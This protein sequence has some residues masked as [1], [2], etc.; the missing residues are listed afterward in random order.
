MTQGS[1]VELQCSQSSSDQNM[2]W[3]HQRSSAGIQLIM[4]SVYMSVPERGKN[5]S[6]RFTSTRPKT[7]NITL[8]ISQA[9]E[10]DTDVQCQSQQKVSQWPSQTL[11]TQGSSVELQCIQSSSDT[12]MYWYCQQSS[13]EIHLIMLSVYKNEPERGKN[14]SGRFTSTR[15][16]TENITLSISQA[17]ESDTDV[18]CQSQ[19]KV[20]QWP[21]QTLMTQGSSVELQCSQSSSD[22]YMYWYCQQS[23]TEIHLIMLSVYMS[24]P[25]RGKNI[26]GRFTSTRPKTENITLSISQAEES[27]TDSLPRSEVLSWFSFVVEP[28]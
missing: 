1:S 24:E 13:T 16:K 14:I 2:Y 20:S 15:P 19:Q 8:S 4:F 23:S 18:Q 21:S 3:Y 11:M 28:G 27:D 7:E 12:Y 5:I 9:E 10:S 6:G 22:T 26:S 17:E 25:E